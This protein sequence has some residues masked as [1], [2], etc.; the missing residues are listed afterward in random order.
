MEK[1]KLLL[2]LCLGLSGLSSCS[3]T[4]PIRV[5]TY[6]LWDGGKAFGKY[7]DR[8]LEKICEKFK[9]A[10][11]DEES[12]DI[13]LIQE[14]WPI[15]ERKNALED[16]GYP[17][18]ATVEQDY[19]DIQ[20]RFSSTI[21]LRYGD[22]ID[23]GMR[24]LSRYPL[25]NPKRHTYVATGSKANAFKDAEYIAHKSVMMVELDHP[26]IGT[27]AVFNTH[28]ISTHPHSNY[29]KEKRFAARGIGGFR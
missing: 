13:I 28:L 16:C 3:E 10:Y 23:T 27:L 14:L 5:L 15:K 8:R 26:R 29:Y 11:E 9:Q 1:I 24:I 25:S 12:W 20:G 7:T 4:V 6:N 17:Y 2:V 21:V 19:D 18:I 22:K